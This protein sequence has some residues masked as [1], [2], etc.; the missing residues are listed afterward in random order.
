MGTHAYTQLGHAVPPFTGHRIGPLLRVG[1]TFHRRST[2]RDLFGWRVAMGGGEALR[3]TTAWPNVGG[4]AGQGDAALRDSSYR[5]DDLAARGQD[6]G[7]GLERERT[8]MSR[9]IRPFA[10]E[11]KQLLAAW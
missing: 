9:E 2:S 3:K 8:K 11:F 5:G 6:G 7:K 10:V 4:T 1:S